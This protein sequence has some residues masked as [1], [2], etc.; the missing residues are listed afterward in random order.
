MKWTHLPSLLQRLRNW[1]AKRLGLWRGR[2][3]RMEIQAQVARWTWWPWPWPWAQGHW[4]CALYR[5][6]GLADEEEAPLVVLL[7]GCGQHAMEFAHA[8][9]LVDV[10]DRDRFR[11]LCP[12]QRERAN[13]WR[14][15]NWFH[16]PAQNGQGELQVV[17]HALEAAAAQVRV[18][19]VAAV[20][21]SAGG[22]LAALLA[23]HHAA[24]F[25]AVVTV[26]APPLLG[27]ASLQDPRKVMKEGLAI[28]PTIATLLI[29]RCAPL[30]VLHGA[31]DD[32][33]TPRCAEQ[34]AAQALHVWKRGA[35][36]E[37]AR[38]ALGDGAEYR[39][40]ERLVLRQRLLPGLA[41]AWSG[42]PGGH[43][44]VLNEGPPLTS[45][46]T[47]FLRETGVL[48]AAR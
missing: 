26:A 44:Y 37:L 11:L 5:P 32:V 20:G 4:D 7:H 1:L 13:A 10:A 23:F 15:W 31:D 27:R 38:T 39:A 25:D 2:W 28:S 29:E 21:L 8:C 47:A 33:V 16:P 34:L 12:E 43:P 36:V 42:A 14:C 17:L 24:R 41:H 35:A 45:L 40:G 18:S 6:A 22:G 30:L 3:L 48:G 9:G 46:A 19:Q